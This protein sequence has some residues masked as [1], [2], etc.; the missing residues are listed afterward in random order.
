MGSSKSVLSGNNGKYENIKQAKKATKGLNLTIDDLQLLCV[1]DTDASRVAYLWLYTFFTL[2]GESAPNKDD[3]RQIPGI[4]TKEIHRIYEAHIT[5]VFTGS[6]SVPL[7]LVA[8]EQLLVE[9]FS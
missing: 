9:Y 7:G 5:A 4:Y 8:F 6:E 3:K 2:L 1:P